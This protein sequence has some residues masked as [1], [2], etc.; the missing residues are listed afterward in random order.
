M[1]L[2]KKLLELSLNDIYHQLISA[3]INISNRTIGKSNIK[4]LQKITGFYI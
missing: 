2:S 1:S 3:T 4:I